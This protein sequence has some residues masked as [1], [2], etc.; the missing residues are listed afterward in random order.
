MRL[1]FEKH[2]AEVKVE[3][4]GD[5]TLEG[6]RLHLVSVIFNLLDNALKYSTGKPNILIGIAGMN[7][8][9]DLSINDSGSVSRQN[10]RARCLKNSSVCPQATCI[11]QKAMA[12]A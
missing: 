4:S 8:R 3:T 11:M 7:D 5:T 9:I 1:Q 6:D 10:T 2:G 12:W